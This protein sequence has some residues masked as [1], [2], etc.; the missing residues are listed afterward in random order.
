MFQHWQ[1]ICSTVTTAPA[2]VGSHNFWLLSLSVM[3][4]VIAA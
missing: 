2:Y 3:V 1:F 4:A